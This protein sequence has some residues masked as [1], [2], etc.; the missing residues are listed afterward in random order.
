MEHDEAKYVTTQ[1]YTDVP[2]SLRNQFASQF[3]FKSTANL[4]PLSF[5]GLAKR[6]IFE[7]G[8]SPAKESALA[9][10][11]TRVAT[12]TGSYADHYTTKA[13]RID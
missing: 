4:N 7:P 5:L 10:I 13:A 2:D 11:R 1:N 8:L 6:S 3:M 9:G 12:V